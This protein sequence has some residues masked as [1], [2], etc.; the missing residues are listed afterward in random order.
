MSA[1][2]GE[3]LVSAIN[4]LLLRLD[5]R[6]V[7]ANEIAACIKP[8]IA[9]SE[10]KAVLSAAK[11]NWSE[12]ISFI[13]AERDQLRQQVANLTHS[14]DSHRETAET[15]R[16]AAIERDKLRAE[17]KESKERERVAIASWD[18]ERQRALREGGQVVELRAEVKQWELA[19]QEQYARAARAEAEVERL[20]AA[21]D[22]ED[23]MA[24]TTIN[25]RDRAEDAADKLASAIL[26]EPIDW[27]D[28]DAKWSEAL[29]E[30]E[31]IH[32][33]KASLSEM[34][35]QSRVDSSVAGIAICNEMGAI[36]RAERAELRIKQLE[37][38]K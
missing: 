11:S 15:W 8:L 31:C 13:I 34:I 4:R 21:S 30:A 26:G 3:T 25:Q 19:F 36:A 33:L 1:A 38:L 29:E 35:A 17:V 22:K 23:S 9:D 37:E 32:D 28:H 18:E 2:N 24:T 10:A 27:P 20:K 12:S 6:G 16:A 7:S 5:A 14:N